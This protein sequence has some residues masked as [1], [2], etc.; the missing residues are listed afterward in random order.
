MKLM[1]CGHVENARTEN[2]DPCC[3]ICMCTEVEKEVSESYGLEGRT[4]KCV[5]GCDHGTPSKWTL[6]F[7]EYRPNEKQDK[8]YCGCW[9]WD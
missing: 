6:P 3:V 4:A 8:Y 7:F 2:G 1:K 5:Y 9:G